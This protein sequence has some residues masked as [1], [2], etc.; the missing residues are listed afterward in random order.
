MPCCGN[1]DPGTL[2]SA[3]RNSRISAVRIEVSWRHPHR[4]QSSAPNGPRPP[5][6]RRRGTRAGEPR[7]SAASS[8]SP[9]AAGTRTSVTGPPSAARSPG[10]RT[11]AWSCRLRQSLADQPAQA[12]VGH[13]AD[14]PGGDP[15]VAADDQRG[16]DARGRDGVAEVERDLV[17]GIVEAWV[18]DAEVAL[19]RLGGRRAVPDVDAEEPDAARGEVLRQPGQERRL[20]PAGRAP[21][22]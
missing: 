8:G 13:L 9:V 16:R 4:A 21:G 12:R 17:T 14:H 20:G 5:G 19:E 2:P 15:A 18:A 1:T 10:H 22:S 6:P 3:S 7:P 11:M